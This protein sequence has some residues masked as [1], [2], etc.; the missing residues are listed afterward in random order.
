M[1]QSKLRIAW[2]ATWSIGTTLL[3]VV[4][5]R[6]FWVTDYIGWATFSNKH[7]ETYCNSGEWILLQNPFLGDPKNFYYGEVM[8]YRA[9]EHYESPPYHRMFGFT[10]LLGGAAPYI[11]ISFAWFVLLGVV[12]AA[13]PYVAPLPS[14]RHFSLRTL[15][16]ATTL[17]A[18]SLGLIMWFAN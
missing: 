7:Y 16:I 11:G 2:S 13:W 17:V 5:I 14:I 10:W 12:F 4:W 1:K 9:A 6:S 15:L 18:T 3:I 8:P